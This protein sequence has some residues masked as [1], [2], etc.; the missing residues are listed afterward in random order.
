[1]RWKG[2][3]AGTIAVIAV[4]ADFN[5]QASGCDDRYPCAPMGETEGQPSPAPVL[6]TSA[7]VKPRSPQIEMT[8]M[9]LS[10]IGIFAG[11]LSV[12]G[13]PQTALDANAKAE[14]TGYARS[15][16]DAEMQSDTDSDVVHVVF[17]DEVNEID[18]AAPAVTLAALQSGAGNAASSPAAMRPASTGENPPPDR[19]MIERLLLVLAGAIAG[20]LAMRRAKNY[21]VKRS[22]SRNGLYAASPH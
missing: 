6:R 10:T 19:I 21:R 11:R 14:T 16:S 13:V 12:P 5:V 1:M 17:A 8:P 7:I 15:A 9:L 3:L 20:A 4:S 18:L 2:I 22:S